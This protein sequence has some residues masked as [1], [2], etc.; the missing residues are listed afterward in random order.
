MGFPPNRHPG[1][2]EALAPP[3]ARAFTWLSRSQ[4]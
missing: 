4:K 1:L 3:L 2:N